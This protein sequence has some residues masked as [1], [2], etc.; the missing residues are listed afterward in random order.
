MK[1]A[2][3]V[4]LLVL[5]HVVSL[6]NVAFG[7]TP[8][9]KKWSYSTGSAIY[10]TCPAIGSDGTIYIGA[11]NGKLY[12][13]NPDGTQKWIYTTGGAIYYSS[14]AIG[15]DGTIYVG[16]QDNR[17][18]A[19]NPDGT[20][21]W[22][23]TTQ[24]DV[25]CSPAIGMDGTIYVGSDD[26]KLYAINPDSTQKWSFTTGGDIGSSPA[27]GP[28]GTI[29]FGSADYKLYAL[30]PS[31]TQK[32]AYSTGSYIY[33]SGPAIGADGTIYVG[34]YNSKFFA[35]NPGGTLKWSY[36]TGGSIYY[37]SPAIGSD[38]TI[39]VGSQDNKVYAFYPDGTKKWA[40]TTP[41]DINSSP[42][43]GA[44]G[45]IY[46]GSS[47]SKI[48]AILPN[49]TLTWSFETLYT[50]GSSP[51]IG[52]D[53]T[54]YVGSNGGYLYA[55]NSNCGGLA[56]AVWPKVRG[57]LRN[58]GRMNKEILISS[59][60]EFVFK[61]P[62]E[63]LWKPISILNNSTSGVVITGCTSDNPSF[64]LETHLPLTV[65]AGRSTQLS[66]RIQ[67]SSSKWY[68]DTC[69]IAYTV[70]GVSQTEAVIVSSG[71]F[72]DDNSELAYAAHKALDAYD[73]CLAADPTSVST[74]NNLGV[75]YRLLGE[76]AL[77]EKNLTEALSAGLNARYGYAGIKINV[78]V[79][80]S[81]KGAPT[82]AFNFYTSSAG[83]I[84]GGDSSSLAPVITYNQA[85]E[86]YKGNSLTQA[87]AAVDKTI[88]HQR[89]NNYLKA[90][91][92]VLRGL[93]KFNSSN[94][95]AAITDMTTAASLDPG[96]PIGAMAE[97]NRRAIV[98]TGVERESDSDLPSD[99]ALFTNYPNPFNP[100]TTIRF[101][102]PVRC[103][104][105]L[106]VF[107]VTGR[108]IKS[109]VNGTMDAGTYS[110]VWRGEDN[111]GRP[112]AS[113][114]YIVKVHAGSFIKTQKA[115]LLK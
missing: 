110:V 96:G 1:L 13:L 99:Y 50:S 9:T 53:G 108:E 69:T 71:I 6:A 91:A 114:V 67:P 74:R 25:D 83:D 36:T 111:M 49:G 18:Y 78:G 39:Y 98:A 51:A 46:V 113:G 40:Y 17:L 64:M 26:N 37:S 61:N 112:L 106:S 43:V 88:T 72:L 19:I 107:D 115:V 41:G 20:K 68:A 15:S 57:N 86:H 5:L 42:A 31:G 76:Y 89:A 56:N 27:I 66:M 105:Q 65:A 45:S 84:A 62:G 93:I 23:F 48:Y 75:L 16:S 54:I 29:Y 85:W 2:P 97:E 90:K 101:Q 58:T 11:Y 94:I 30:T 38:G 82:E 12:A 21:K 100:T 14:P 70:S 7:Q 79:V 3:F 35:I 63:T 60:P 24:G 109:L 55:L 73:N 87:L 47:D 81:D 8:G 104:V 59:Q 92:Y 10:Y 80:R 32:W 34:S 95:D 44:D 102:L 103:D 4:K 52:P 33:F 28:D 77:A 22:T